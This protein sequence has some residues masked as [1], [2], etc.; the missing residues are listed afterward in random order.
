MLV[1]RLLALLVALLSL[2]LA[3]GSRPE[4]GSPDETG[5][6]G[7]SAGSGGEGGAL[8]E[9]PVPLVEVEELVIQPEAGRGFFLDALA[10][11]RDQVRLQIYAITDDTIE[12]AL[13]A[14]ARRGVAVRILIPFDNEPNAEA[15]AKFEEAGIELRDDPPEFATTHQKSMVVDDDLAFVLTQNLSFSG[16]EYYR[17]YNA[18][19]RGEVAR[20]VAAIFEADWSGVPFDRETDLVLSPLNSRQRLETLI[21]AAEESI[22]VAI[23]VATDGRMIDLLAAKARQGTRVRVLLRDPSS[24]EANAA[25]A[26]K[27]ASSGVDVRWLP[28]P[29]LHAKAMV[30]DGRW[31]YLGSVNFT[32]WSLD[33]NRELGLVTADEEVLTKI[34]STF[35]ADFATGRTDF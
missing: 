33:R 30:I 10:S 20:E 17:E 24:I 6:A 1:R 18:V 2:Q 22:D 19:V 23:E 4:A 14:T 32:T 9:A 34:R 5:G 21:K 7:G 13:I 8:D 28:E 35:E 29:G 15:L 25:G 26:R 3:C 31:A 27:M 11:A 12:E 16:F